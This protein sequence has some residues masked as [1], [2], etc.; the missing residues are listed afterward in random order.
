MKT[1]PKSYLALDMGLGKT[2]ITLKWLE[3][4]L[5]SCKG[6]L[7]IA[8][9]RTI[10]TTWPDEI[11]KWTPGLTYTILHGSK[12]VENLHRKVD[13]YLMNYESLPWLFEALKH[14]H[15][16]TGKIPFKVLAL[17]EGSM[18]KS[19]STKRFKILKLL[20]PLF[21]DYMTILSGTPAPNNLLDLWSQYYLLDEGER[22]EKYITHYKQHYFWQVDRMGYKWLI[23]KGADQVIYSKIADITYRLDSKDYTELPEMIHN[24]IKVPLGKKLQAQ[25]KLLEKDFFLAL[26]DNEEMAVF[27]AA[28][29]SMKLRQFLQGAVY[30]DENHNYTVFHEEKLK[31]LKSMVEEAGG[32]SILC[33]IQFRFELDMIKKVFPKVPYIAGGVSASTAT[34][35]I[36]QWNRGELPLLLCHPASLSHGVNL[37]TGGHT[38][39]WYGLTWSLEQ[40]LQLNKRLH[41]NGQKSAVVIH[42]L[43]VPDSVDE[44]VMKA[45]KAKFKTQSELLDYLRERRL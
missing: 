44:R 19:H 31:V 23:N 34:K 5:K 11:K 30:T 32:S 35:L 40:Y 42:H 26:D 41:R 28:S 14:Y 21:P 6:A 45:L 9:L 16:A 43:I 33:A 25:Y 39:L 8:P 1:C 36:N 7:V 38:V 24:V 13:L 15:K 22:L 2:A 10:S 4:V 17:D 3:H 20:R 12:K 27:N 37:Q 18:V 29:L